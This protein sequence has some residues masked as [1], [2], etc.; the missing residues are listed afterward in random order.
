[1]V[2]ISFA[3]PDD[4][5]EVARFM[6]LSF[7]RAKWGPEAWTRLL[8]G[9]WAGPD[10]RFAITARDNG[11]LVGV[12][13]LVCATRHTPDGPR[14]TANMTSWY[15][16]QTHRGQGLGSAMLG[17]LTAQPDLTVTDVSSSK[18]AVPVVERAGFTVL[19]AD[20]LIWRARG[21]TNALPVTLAPLDD[22]DL[23]AVDRQ[24]ITDHAGLN[25]KPVRV[26]TDDGPCTLVLSIKQKHD[27]YVTHEV[28][29][30]GQ[31]DI[32]GSHA[33][34]IADAVLPEGAAILSV[35]RRLVPAGTPAEATETFAVARYYTPG[36]MDPAYLDHMYSEIVLLDMKLY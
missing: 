20:R 2:D 10:G 12:L 26:L 6:H 5:A 1:M 27:D 7:P 32:F 25:L 13:G 15:V 29:Y 11:A 34:A 17:L 4:R 33:R 35:D 21:T 30:L 23:P 8:D 19:D 3:P 24:V 9:R 16:A 18:A 36:H 31:P 14:N 28:M 22:P